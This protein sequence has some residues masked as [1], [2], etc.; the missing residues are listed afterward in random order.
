MF[1][2]LYCYSGMFLLTVSS[3]YNYNFSINSCFLFIF[4]CFNFL[5]TFTL[6]AVS[7]AILV[8]SLFQLKRLGYGKIKD[9]NT[10]LIATSSLDNIVSI[11]AF[12]ILL[13]VLFRNGK[14]MRRVPQSDAAVG[15]DELNTN[16]VSY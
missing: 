3:C 7:P 16:V 2:F 13:G 8:P 11:C 14:Y 1:L 12:R 10:L 9:I 6:S 5:Q 15:P 4:F